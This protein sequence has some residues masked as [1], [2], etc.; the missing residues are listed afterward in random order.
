MKNISTK[1]DPTDQICVE[2]FQERNFL[3][4]KKNRTK[5]HTEVGGG[6]WN[7][8]ITSYE[9]MRSGEAEAAEEARSE[10]PREA[11]VLESL[12]VLKLLAQTNYDRD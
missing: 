5:N 6:D 3:K 9:V 10:A 1:Y 4:I 7:L 11:S 8:V 2:M 12:R